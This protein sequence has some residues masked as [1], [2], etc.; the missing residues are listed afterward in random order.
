MRS[1]LVSWPKL[2]DYAVSYPTESSA[3]AYQRAIVLAIW[4]GSEFTLDHLHAGKVGRRWSMRIWRWVGAPLGRLA[5]RLDKRWG[6]AAIE[7]PDYD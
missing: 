2:K 3:P 7:P 4:A 1:T 5:Y 6:T